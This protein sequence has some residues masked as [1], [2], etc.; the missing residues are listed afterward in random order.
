[1]RLHLGE[2]EIDLRGQTRLHR[3]DVERRQEL[4]GVRLAVLDIGERTVE[5]RPHIGGKVVLGKH[6]AQ[7]RGRP[8]AEDE[9]GRGPLIAPVLPGLLVRPLEGWPIPLQQLRLDPVGGDVAARRLIL[10]ELQRADHLIRLR[11]ARRG[12]LFGMDG[13][14]AVSAMGGI[15]GIGGIGVAVGGFAVLACLG[16]VVAGRGAPVTVGAII[17]MGTVGFAMSAFFCGVISALGDIAA[18]P[19]RLAGL[20]H[21]VAGAVAGLAVMRLLP[22]RRGREHEGKERQDRRHGGNAATHQARGSVRKI[23]MRRLIAD[24]GFCA[25]L[26]SRSAKPSMAFTRD[27]SRP[28][29]A[30]M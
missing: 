2:G 27:S 6:H 10:Q 17:C 16:L 20:T 22:R 28:P 29:R 9:Q 15:G 13:V 12:R 24:S 11:S 8:A 19:G 23:S 26:S 21:R 25:S 30:S 7:H 14:I 18:P 1:M 5:Q 4:L 3:V